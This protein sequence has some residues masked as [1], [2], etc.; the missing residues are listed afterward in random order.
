MISFENSDIDLNSWVGFEYPSGANTDKLKQRKNKLTSQNK[1]RTAVSIKDGSAG[2]SGDYKCAYG[3]QSKSISVT[4]NEK[5]TFDDSAEDANGKQL[6]VGT[7]S[8]DCKAQPSGL[9]YMWTVGSEE[10]KEG[11]TLDFGDGVTKDFDENTEYICEVTRASTGDYDQL[12]YKFSVVY[13]PEVTIPESSFVRKEGDSASLVCNVD[14]KPAAD[15][16]WS[17]DGKVIEGQKETTLKLDNLTFADHNGKYKCTANNKIGNEATGE[18]D[19]TVVVPP[20]A[21]ITQGESVNVKEGDKLK[22]E[23]TASGQPSPTK[24]IWTLP[25]GTQQPEGSTFKTG[26]NEINW[27]V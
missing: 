20:K 5:L 8:F 9:K 15:I 4:F 16:T 11:K 12:V 18:I 14:A 27:R 23:C 26:S 25:D 6:E 7:K 1:I 17:R 24:F 19:V 13:A 22:L 2:L 21:T 10:P 3:D